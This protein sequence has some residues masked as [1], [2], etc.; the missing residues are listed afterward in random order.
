MNLGLGVLLRPTRLIPA[1]GRHVP[2]EGVP[3]LKITD[4]DA[5]PLDVHLVPS[6]SGIIVLDTQEF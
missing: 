1:N 4:V 3:G 5:V 2:R 6:C